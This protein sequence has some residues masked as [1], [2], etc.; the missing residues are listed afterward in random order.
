MR[1]STS[2]KPAYFGNR[3]FAVMALAIATVAAL[4]LLAFGT[5]KPALAATDNAHGNLSAGTI[6]SQASSKAKATKASAFEYKVGRWIDTG[7]V[8]TSKCWY[9][10]KTINGIKTLH[11]KGKYGPEFLIRTSGG[12]AGYGYDCGTGVYITGFKGSKYSKVVVPNK[13]G[14]KPVV[15]VALMGE[16]IRSLDVSQCKYLKALSIG[17]ESAGGTNCTIGSIKFGKNPK[18]LH[19][20]LDRSIVNAKVNVT[21]TNLRVLR[22]MFSYLKKGFS[23]KAPKLRAFSCYGFNDLYLDTNRNL[24]SLYVPNCKNCK[25]NLAGM[26][27]LT[28]LS[29]DR[30][31]LKRLDI[32]KNK[33]LEYISATGNN[34]DKKTTAAL[35]KWQKA[36]K[37]R[38]LSL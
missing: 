3:S 17:Y 28:S 22:I 29:V 18:L 31:N 37:G 36:K 16:K 2:H 13:I 12:G 25:L 24:R 15:C 11:A 23:F 21:P 8:Q 33:K 5:A 7:K 19:F 35:K 38:T 34:F 10:T 26:P 4:V 30:C 14:G 6:A 9:G 20:N 1:E 27:K 32:S